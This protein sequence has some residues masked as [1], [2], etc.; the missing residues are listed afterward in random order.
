MAWRKRSVAVSIAAHMT[1][2]IVSV[3]LIAAGLATGD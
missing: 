2:N 1:I 3:L